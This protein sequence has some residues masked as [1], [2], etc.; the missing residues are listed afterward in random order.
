MKL[1]PGNECMVIGGACP[2]LPPL[3]TPLHFIMCFYKDY[4]SPINNY[5]II[6]CTD[7]KII[8]CTIFH[9]K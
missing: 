7:L 8:T 2:S 6:K 4:G 9:F 5:V 1:F 3:N